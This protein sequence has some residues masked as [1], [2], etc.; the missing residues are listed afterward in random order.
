LSMES[1]AQARDSKH[2]PFPTLN[3]WYAF[4]FE[5]KR[6]PTAEEIRAAIA[7]QVQP[8][9][10]PPIRNIGV[11]GIRK[12]A[13]EIPQWPA[14][15]DADELRL[16][17][18]NAWIFISPEGGSGGGL[19][20]YMFS[21]FLREAAEITQ[22][23]GLVQSADAFQQIGDRWAELGSWF[24]EVAR[25]EDPA[26]RLGECAGPMQALADLEEDGWRALGKTALDK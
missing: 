4:D 25:A 10:A 22:D 14:K 24:Q 15:L 21:R 9:L 2:R 19:F 7:E 18:F 12:A 8:M 6:Q 20:R 13:G 5:R 26:A 23:A 1:L 3:K 11:K 16:A 17:L